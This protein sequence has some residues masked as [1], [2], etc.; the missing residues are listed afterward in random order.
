MTGPDAIVAVTKE[1]I[2]DNKAIQWNINLVFTILIDC[3]TSYHNREHEIYIPLDFFLSMI[4]SLV[5]S[6]I[7]LRSLQWDGAQSYHY[8]LRQMY[9]Y[10]SYT[11]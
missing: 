8:T 4:N 10:T 11:G 6:T 5:I 9:M 7:A 2:F 1:I 3:G